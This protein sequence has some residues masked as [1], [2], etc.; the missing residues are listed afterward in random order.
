MGKIKVKLNKEAS[1]NLSTR[2]LLVPG[3]NEV[4]EDLLME[5]A[6]KP[7]NRHFFENGIIEPVHPKAVQLGEP[8]PALTPA[9]AYIQPNPEDDEA[10]QEAVALLAG[11]IVEMN[12]KDAVEA[13]GK[14]DRIEVLVAIAE[15][16]KRKTVMEAV[17]TRAETLAAAEKAPQDTQDEGAASEE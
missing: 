7:H 2:L 15:Q 6:E 12:A 14:V 10:H 5:L 3:V 4:D 13:V 9:S 11:E 8:Q 1:V 17:E 16:E